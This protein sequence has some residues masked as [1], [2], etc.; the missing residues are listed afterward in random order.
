MGK[1]IAWLL[2]GEKHEG[3]RDQ[4]NDRTKEGV[5]VVKGDRER[6]R[7]RKTVGECASMYTDRRKQGK[8]MRMSKRKPDVRLG[9]PYTRSNLS[10][11]TFLLAADKMSRCIIL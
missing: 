6:E 9:R 11:A 10:A 3:R 2:W 4:R 8:G 7:E 1:G 5:G